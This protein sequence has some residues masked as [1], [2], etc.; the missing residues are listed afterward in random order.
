MALRLT[1]LHS[2]FPIPGLTPMS[3]VLDL[4]TELIRREINRIDRVRFD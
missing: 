3:L 1:I 4:T 2:L